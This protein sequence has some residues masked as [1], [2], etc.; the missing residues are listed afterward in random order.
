MARSRQTKYL[1]IGGGVAAARAVGS[2]R[3][4]DRN[5]AIVLVTDEPRMPYDRPPLSKGIITGDVRAREISSNR[6]FFYLKHR[7]R[8]LRRTSVT[9]LQ[10]EGAEPEATLSDG[11]RVRFE[12]ALIATGGRPRRLRVPGAELSGIHTLRTVADAQ[13]IAA[14]SGDGKAAVIV[15]GGFIGLELAASLSQV[16]TRVTLVEPRDHLWP[17]STPP[18]LSEYLRSYLES[19]GVTVHTG[20][21]VEAFV[22]EERVRAVRTEAVAREQHA[23]AARAAGGEIACDFVCVAVGIE[24]NSSLAE[25]AGL[26][27]DDG[28][29]VDEKVCTSDPRIFAA[30]DVCRFR[31]PFSGAAR[32]VEH[33]ENAEYGGLLAGANMAEADRRYDFLPTLWSDIGALTIDVAGDETRYDSLVERGRLPDIAE[34]SGRAPTAATAYQTRTH[35]ERAKKASDGNSAQSGWIA[36]GFKDGQPLCYFALGARR[37]DLSAAQLLIRNRAQGAEPGNAQTSHMR[38]QLADSSRALPEIARELLR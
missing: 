32:R 26:E 16:G 7:V 30:G 14:E 4:L 12:R 25:S 15:G 29:L 31:D 36:I 3:D 5:G 13:S 24:P 35:Q 27:T 28:I 38:E 33:H 9:A 2:I 23:P 6:R 22:G 20:I 18:A 34:P 21:A 37:A 1:L 10:L 19:L 11:G 8:I 17:P